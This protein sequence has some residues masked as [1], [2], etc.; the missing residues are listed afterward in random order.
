VIEEAKF[1]QQ[2]LE[3]LAH[4]FELSGIYLVLMILAKAFSING[5][6]AQKL[7]TLFIS[8]AEIEHY[9]HPFLL[10]FIGSNDSTGVT[11]LN[12]LL[13]CVTRWRRCI[14]QQQSLK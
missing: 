13:C 11:N 2:M 4:C 7:F 3:L 9:L 14:I 12:R 1:W 6:N 10:A 5:C 8:L